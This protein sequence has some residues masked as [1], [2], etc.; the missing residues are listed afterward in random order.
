MISTPPAANIPTLQGWALVA[1]SLLLVLSAAAVAP[2]GRRFAGRPPQ[3]AR[4]SDAEDAR[5]HDLDGGVYRHST[6]ALW[7]SCCR[8]SCH[9]DIP[10]RPAGVD[11]VERKT[12]DER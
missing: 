8:V 3:C 10:Q 1:L 11:R 12:G 9:D 6:A 2:R 5:G 4:R 7:N